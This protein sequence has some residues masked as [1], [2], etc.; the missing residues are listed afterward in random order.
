MLLNVP[1]EVLDL[2]AEN[3]FQDG[4]KF[5]GHVY[6]YRDVNQ[7]TRVCR[8]LHAQFNQK[9]YQQYIKTEG[10]WPLL[11]GSAKGY[12]TTVQMALN[13][14]ADIRQRG[15]EPG[16]ESRL[17]PGRD[18]ESGGTIIWKGDALTQAVANGQEATVRMLIETG[19]I[20]MKPSRTERYH[21]PLWCA[22]YFGYTDLIH[23]LLSF[24]G[25]NINFIDGMGK[26]ALEGAIQ[27][28]QLRSVLTLLAYPQ[29]DLRARR[30]P[31][32]VEYAIYEETQDIACALIRDPR[33]N[34]NGG[35]QKGRPYVLSREPLLRAMRSGQQ[36]VIRCL[37][38]HPGIETRG[39]DLGWTPIF[40]A[41]CTDSPAA[42]Q[43]LLAMPGT[44]PHI[45][46]REGQ[47]ALMVAVR[48]G[49][50]RTAGVLAKVK[51]TN[52]NYQD[53]NGDTALMLAV[54]ANNIGMV[55]FLLK[56]EGVDPDIK[57]HA[58]HSAVMM[59]RD[60]FLKELFVQPQASNRYD[61]PEEFDP[62]RFDPDGF[63]L[64]DYN[65]SDSD[66]DGF[67]TESVDSES[68]GTESE[69]S[70]SEHL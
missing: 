51:G 20:D 57:N 44:N 45:P 2:I 67:Y 32:P 40:L 42:V 16:C 15:K 21:S 62:F 26:T 13:A 48:E 28:K 36:D 5:Y 50:P 3:L 6:R 30:G 4:Q 19:K 33:S 38:E 8:I 54:S 59:A 52:L 46:D 24:P 47:T 12:I 23:L 69:D 64:D 49:N 68:E 11:F 17:N 65:P 35:M 9:M 31:N 60:P 37:L 18:L 70:E 58:G 53:K 66:P 10:V 22:C 25:I 27:G 39:S 14:G 29:L 55:S 34:P 63:D 7:L 43:T 61:Y 56:C 1:V 41:A